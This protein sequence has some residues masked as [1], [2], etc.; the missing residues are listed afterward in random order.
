MHVADYQVVRWCQ[1]TSL[2]MNLDICTCWWLASFILF[3]PS[4]FGMINVDKSQFDNHIF[5]DGWKPPVHDVYSHGSWKPDVPHLWWP[6]RVLLR[7][8]AELDAEDLCMV[9]WKAMAQSS[10][11]R[12]IQS[13]AGAVSGRNLLGW[14]PNPRCRMPTP[15]W[16]RHG[17]L[18]CL[19]RTR[20]LRHHLTPGLGHMVTIGSQPNATMN[21][22]TVFEANILFKKAGCPPCQKTNL[23]TLKSLTQNKNIDETISCPIA[24]TCSL[25]DLNRLQQW[26]QSQQRRNEAI[27][28]AARYFGQGDRLH[29]SALHLF[30][31]ICRS[32]LDSLPN[33]NHL[34][35]GCGWPL[36]CY[37]SIM[38]EV[39]LVPIPSEQCPQRASDSWGVRRTSSAGHCDLIGKRG[40]TTCLVAGWGI[41][42]T[43]SRH[44]RYW[45]LKLETIQQ[46]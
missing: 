45:R 36:V 13:L 39:E 32:K 1:S 16:K 27:V 14:P 25:L 6:R 15:R 23:I 17:R 18:L 11:S 8:K 29:S 2:G 7:R 43:Y 12:M 46:C 34:L 4:S 31:K 24:V 22:S 10:M 35:F 20:A 9:T 44:W 42:D 28:F 21:T 3:F 40:G 37:V 41:W 33:L 38:P 5:P 19:G 30:Q 26:R